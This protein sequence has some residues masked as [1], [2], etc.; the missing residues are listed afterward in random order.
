MTCSKW[1][2][3][4]KVQLRCWAL[5]AGAALAFGF[6]GIRID[7]PAMLYPV[8]GDVEFAHDPSAIKA[9][10]LW[11]V[12]TTGRGPDGGLLGV[13]TSED[14]IHWKNA[15]HVFDKMPDWI[16]QASPRTRDLWAPDISFENGEFRLY[17]AYSLFGRN[18]S[19][20]A[21]ATNKTLDP[22]NPAYKWED[23]GLVL[24]STTTDDY[25][26]ID[27]NYVKD[28]EGRAWLVLG[29]FW[30]GI[31]M[32]E[33]DPE[34]GKRLASNPTKYAVAA[35]SRHTPRVSP[36][37]KLPPD[38]TAIEAPYI[39]HH[40]AYYYLFVSWDMCCRGLQ[41]NYKTVVGRSKDVTGPYVDRDRVPMADGGGTLL[42]GPGD[43]WVGAGG[44][45]VL[46]QRGAPD[47]I[48]FHAYNKVDGRP[49]LEVSTISWK[50]GW[51]T[52]SN[53]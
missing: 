12:F 35:R 46:M 7:P 37:A 23:K 1:S 13:R 48:F 38:N 2:E 40:G 20:I 49:S 50:D 16:T 24:A 47:L 44:E 18:T 52:V 9:G 30:S 51:P 6:T 27:P 42:L 26:A 33:L 19:G 15:G 3:S 14:L 43:K 32:F 29:S 34:T 8:T 28:R 10:K 39:V 17:Y 25:N 11:Y 5:G 21:L 41:S 31:K 45:S 4:A 36:D 22:K 53:G